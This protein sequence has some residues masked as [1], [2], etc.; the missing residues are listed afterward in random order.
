MALKE[1]FLDEDTMDVLKDSFD[2]VKIKAGTI[3]TAQSIFE[4]AVHINLAKIPPPKEQPKQAM[5]S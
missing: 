3:K 1:K 5:P 2:N 4:G